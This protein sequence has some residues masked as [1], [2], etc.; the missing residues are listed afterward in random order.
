M[1][2]S[3]AV[4]IA[5]RLVEAF[6]P[7]CE[8]IQVAGSIRRKKLDVKDIELVLIPRWG[9]RPVEG[10]AALLGPNVEPVNRLQEVVE[11]LQ[12]RGRLQ[13]IKPG[14]PDVHAWHLERDGRYWRLYLPRHELKV[15]VFLTTP[16]S[17]G[18]VFMMRTGSAA[19]SQAMLARWKQVSGGGF[20]RDALLWRPGHRTPEVHPDESDVFRLCQ[21]AW[22][23]PEFRT[24]ADAVDRFVLPAPH[25]VA[26]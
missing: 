8:R 12:E 7:A 1:E 2:Y 19:F 10:Q 20:S 21:V 3:R 6:G 16:A 4:A 11:D 13:V 5:S 23:L 24:G 15:D 25:G 9:E 22:V 18:L 26:S 17:W 14:T